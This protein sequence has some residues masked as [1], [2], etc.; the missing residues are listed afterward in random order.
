MDIWLNVSLGLLA[1]LVG[2]VGYFLK[3]IHADFR[4]FKKDATDMRE[5]VIR[6]EEK[7]ANLEGLVRNQG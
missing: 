7:V 2:V 1:A 5:R 3:L 4:D 6:I